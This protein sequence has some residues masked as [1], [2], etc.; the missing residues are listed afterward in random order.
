MPNKVRKQNGRMTKILIMEMMMDKIPIQIKCKQIEYLRQSLEIPS[1][2]KILSS[3]PLQEDDKLLN[4]FNA[5]ILQTSNPDHSYISRKQIEAT[6]LNYLEKFA[7]RISD[8]IELKVD[9]VD[10]E[11]LQFLNIIRF[12]GLIENIESMLIQKASLEKNMQIDS[13][14][15]PTE[16]L[17][18]IFLLLTNQQQIKNNMSAICATI[19]FKNVQYLIHCFN[20]ISKQQRTKVKNGD[21]SQ[22]VT[23]VKTQQLAQTLEALSKTVSFSQNVVYLTSELQIHKSIPYLIHFNCPA[24]LQ[25]YLCMQIRMTPAI[26][27][28]QAAAFMIIRF[29]C[30][31]RKVNNDLTKFHQIRQHSIHHVLQFANEI[32]L[33]QDQQ[34]SE[35]QSI[36]R[37]QSRIVKSSLQILRV[38]LLD[39]QVHYQIEAVFPNIIRSLIKLHNYKLGKGVYQNEEDEDAPEIRLNSRFCLSWIQQHADYQTLIILIN[40]NYVGTM[41]NAISNDYGHEQ[42]S[43]I[44]VLDLIS[45]I[46]YFFTVLHEEIQSNKKNKKFAFFLP[47]VV[48]AKQSEEQIE[49]EGGI[50]EVELRTNKGNKD[51]IKKQSAQTM[52]SVRNLYL[53]YLNKVQ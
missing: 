7:V 30:S 32:P 25:C 39:N 42:N 20:N 2:D 52:N 38:I 16:Q 18:R 15:A 51:Q 4:I 49:E 17:L 45:N 3:I 48:F 22:K 36:F 8:M 44:Q 12:S 29:F 28:L 41:T 1:I 46:H 14:S 23:D 5:D 13:Y 35:K 43:N 34:T 26:Y 10:N 31:Y 47:D 50:E 21:V 11:D 40:E 6:L 37:S 9:P 53:D 19:V 27:A 33:Q 24:E